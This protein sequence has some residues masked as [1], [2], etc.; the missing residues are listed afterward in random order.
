MR[1]SLFK[2][3][4]TRNGGFMPAEDNK[5][6]RRRMIEDVREKISSLSEKELAQKKQGVIKQLFD[7]ANYLEAKIAMLY[8]PGDEL[9][10]EI[11]DIFA[12]SLERGKVV[13]FPFFGKKNENIKFYKVDNIKQNLIRSES[14]KMLPDKKICR[15]IPDEYIDIAVIPGMAFDEKGGR[16]AFNKAD[17][18]R[19]IANLPMTTRKIALCLE[20]QIV[21]QIPMESKK[22]YVD[23]II[24][25]ER[26]IYKI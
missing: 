17:Y 2:E 21:S 20:E 23:M 10:F 9:E 5:E 19:L 24:T 12:K 3:E 7:F 15:E 13:T 26:I 6:K 25:N 1:Q 11:E 8:Y 22:R 14:G 4:N 18:D 16:I